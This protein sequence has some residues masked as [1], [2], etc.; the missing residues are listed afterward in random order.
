LG[1]CSGRSVLHVCMLC[2]LVWTVLRPGTTSTLLSTRH[3]SKLLRVITY[4][5]CVLHVVYMDKRSYL[6]SAILA[7]VK[8]LLLRPG[9][10]VPHDQDP[11]VQVTSQLRVPLLQAQQTAEDVICTATAGCPVSSRQELKNLLLVGRLVRPASPTSRPLISTSP[12][13]ACR[14]S[15]ATR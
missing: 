8:Q 2:S 1:S 5:G 6:E 9:G 13:A 11:I 4:V 7:A 14:T 3:Q 15:C 12:F 10:A